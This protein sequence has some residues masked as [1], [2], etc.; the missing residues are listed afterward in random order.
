MWISRL[1]HIQA[2]N[3]IMPRYLSQITLVRAADGVALPPNPFEGVVLS[4]T[5]TSWHSLVVE[6][7]HWSSGSCEVNE[8][9][10]YVPHVIT[11]NIGRSVT[12]QYRKAG[13]FRDVTKPK[14]AISLFPSQRP[15]FRRVGSRETGASD[16]LYLALDPVFVSR[17]ATDLEFYPDRLELIEKLGHTDPA[18]QHIALALQAVLQ[19]GRSS[20]KLYGESLALALAVHLLREYAAQPVEPH[21]TP[22]GLSREQLMRAVDYIEDQL[23]EDLTVA[24][25]A[26]AVHMSPFHFTRLFKRAT[27]QS[28]YHYVIEARAKRAKALLTSRKFSISE[29]AHPTG[30]A[31]QSHLTHHV[32]KFYG[33]T[34]KMLLQNQV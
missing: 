29:V 11:V 3:A 6:E 16:F 17:A 1:Q 13:R 19:T 20:D 18:L 23:H 32:K 34:P 8:D 7:H 33:V 10:K 31:D 26:R 24:G 2:C 30:F 27:G 15:F 21:I 5:S 9:V 12:A 25:I 4:S 28:P 14:G 22:G